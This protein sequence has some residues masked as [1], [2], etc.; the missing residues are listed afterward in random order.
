MI[1]TNIQ[2]K[3]I[4]N[5]NFD[6]QPNVL[7]LRSKSL[8]LDLSSI[9][10]TQQ[11]TLFIIKIYRRTV[12]QV[13]A[14]SQNINC[15]TIKTIRL[16]QNI[17][18]GLANNF[19]PNISRITE[20]SLFS[21]LTLL[22][23]SVY[24]L[25]IFLVFFIKF[26]I[27]VVDSVLNITNVLTNKCILQSQ[28][29]ITGCHTTYTQ[30]ID[31]LNNN[32]QTYKHKINTQLNLITQTCID[33]THKLG[34]N[35][36][37]VLH[38]NI[39][40]LEQIYLNYLRV[41]KT[42]LNVKPVIL[43]LSSRNYANFIFFSIMASSVALLATQSIWQYQSLRHTKN[44]VQAISMQGA[45]QLKNG[46]QNIY[47]QQWSEG[48]NNFELAF[49]SFQNAQKQL[50]NSNFILQLA[51]HMNVSKVTSGQSLLKA[52]ES[53]AIT[54]NK[55]TELFEGLAKFKNITFVDNIN[56]KPSAAI[57]ILTILQK[58]TEE[59]NKSLTLTR[60]HLRSVAIND[61]PENLQTQF[62]TY[63]NSID[64]AHINFQ[65]LS[66][67]FAIGQHI[68]AA[69][70]SQRYMIVF[71]NNHEI[72]PTGGFMGSF[73]IL[74]ISNG[75]IQNINIPAGG[76]YDL[77]G[78]LRQNLIPPQ[79]LQ[80]ISSRWEFQD[81]NWW[82][83]FPTSAKKIIWFYNQSD[84]VNEN[85]PNLAHKIMGAMSDSSLIDPTNDSINE[86]K[87]Q[88][89]KLIKSKQIDGVIAIN[90]TFL[91]KL[92]TIV[93]PIEMKK[94]K[95]TITSE[96]FRLETQ[97]IVELEYNRSEN[98]PKEFIGDLTVEVL[99]KLQQLSLK[100][101]INILG[102]VDTALIEKDIL[103]YLDDPYLNFLTEKNQ[104]N[105]KIKNIE[106]DLDYL[107]IVHT[108]IAGGKTNGAL[109]DVVKHTATIQAD[110]SIIDTLEITRTHN[111]IKNQNFSGI[112]NVDYLRVYVPQG[113]TLLSATGFER[114]D[115]K[116]FN[117][118]T[119]D[120][121]IDYDLNNLEGQNSED[122][123]TNTIIGTQFNKT[124]FGNWV[125]IDPGYTKTVKITYKLPFKIDIKNID[126][127][128]LLVQN[129]SGVTSTQFQRNLVLPI[130]S[131]I[132]YTYPENKQLEN[133][134]VY[135][136]DLKHD[137]LL[138]DILEIN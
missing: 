11:V 137:I 72:R 39:A 111:G 7:D 42:P 37:R 71:Q 126:T 98:K 113:S 16:C 27:Q 90:A 58:H 59:I 127:Y 57:D 92:L 23:Y 56:L 76:T 32:Y 117:Q 65:R 123:L 63:K 84:G 103:I 51:T 53:L 19:L 85:N 138:A 8:T 75:T 81:A 99:E 118:I 5:P 28:Q 40:N 2:I 73:A 67:V 116:W 31:I 109:K 25:V 124:F 130:N 61:I 128:K 104:W 135:T 18:V 46:L 129:Q 47:N 22:V 70:Q 45:H 66:S 24:N 131:K 108:N 33:N 34:N 36:F 26:L 97:K 20:T 114:P 101:W 68:F 121:Q 80:L 93:E 60:F 120:K 91:E 94:Y 3:N 122:L 1:T 79:P 110:G 100:S 15:V 106:S 52:G 9:P 55:M 62:I 69:Q 48:V 43:T 4:L 10:L 133:N 54:S 78:S 50:N 82:S 14:C 95:R 83:D 21:L 134:T 107:H 105:G 112:R 88:A 119:E 89:D 136:T 49:N 6:I 30:T 87:T 13:T 125:Q 38:A 41:L 86:P 115:Q 44:I 74:D 64:M 29:L 12:N 17:Q 102:L 132:I 77:Q 35:I 96:N